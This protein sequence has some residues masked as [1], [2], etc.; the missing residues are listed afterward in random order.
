M[1]NV[2]STVWQYITEVISCG[3]R[4]PLYTDNHNN[5]GKVN[6]IDY[7]VTMVSC[8]NTI[9]ASQHVVPED[10]AFKKWA[11]IRICVSLR[12]AKLL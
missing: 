5:D 4:A 1:C 7:F 8:W 9:A 6:N 2:D 11:S 10:D 3:V 12:R